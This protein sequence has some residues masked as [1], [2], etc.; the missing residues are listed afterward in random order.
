[1]VIRTRGFATSTGGGNDEFAYAYCTDENGYCLSVGR[2]PGDELVEVMVV[3]QV[4]HKTRAVLVELSRGELRLELSA[5][6][7]AH[8]DGITKYT[9]P[10]DATDEEFRQLDAALSAIFEGGSRGQYVRS[11]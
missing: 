1:M 10:L 3:D 5:A 2:F 8:L 11:F 9:V 4:N 7:A 6:A